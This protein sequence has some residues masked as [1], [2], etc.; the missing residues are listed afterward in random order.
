MQNDVPPSLL[1]LC[2]PLSPLS[3][4][5]NT[6]ATALLELTLKAPAVAGPPHAPLPE[7]PR[8]LLASLLLRLSLLTTVFHHLGSSSGDCDYRSAP[9]CLALFRPNKGSTLSIPTKEKKIEQLSTRQYTQALCDLRNGSG[10]KMHVIREF[11]LFPNKGIPVETIV[12]EFLLL[13]NKGIPVE[14]NGNLRTFTHH[15]PT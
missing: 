10:T 12:G 5:L 13:P 9:R 2:V 3:A 1:R 14:T 15:Y 4:A 11:L 7:H 6:V 8:R